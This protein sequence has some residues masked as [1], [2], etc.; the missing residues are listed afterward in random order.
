[1][2]RQK[3][4]FFRLIDLTLAQSNKTSYYKATR[5]DICWYE[6]NHLTWGSGTIL[7]FECTSAVHYNDSYCHLYCESFSFKITWYVHT[8]I[9]RHWLPLVM[10]GFVICE[11]IGW[12]GDSVQD[13][14]YKCTK[15]SC[16]TTLTVSVKFMWLNYLTTLSQSMCR[17]KLLK[18]VVKY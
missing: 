16:S 12:V 4:F 14:I 7:R 8:R 2:S 10:I 13:F 3:S 1:M 18:N 11:Q 15:D 5:V 17:N 6:R 9:A